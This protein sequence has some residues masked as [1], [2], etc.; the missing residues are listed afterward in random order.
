MNKKIIIS[1]IAILIVAIGGG[2]YYTTSKNNVASDGHTDHS[3]DEA[4][5]MGTDMEE[6]HNMD[7]M[8]SGAELAGTRI[9]VKN[10][11]FKSGEQVLSFVVYGKD[12]HE[13]GDKDL[14]VTHEKKMHFIMASADFSSYQHIH[15]EF[16]D[17]SWQATILLNNNTAY[18]AYVDIDST[19][20]GA[21]VL[22][23]PIAVGAP[24]A[25]SKVSQK[26]TSV[27]KDGVEV[28]LNAENGFVTGKDNL[29]TFTLS[30]GGKNIVPENYL[31]AKGHVIA[32][33]EDP[34]SFIHGHPNE[35]GDNDTHFAFNFAKAGTYTLF[36]QFQV[37]GAVNTYPFTITVASSN[38][39]VDESKPHVDAVP[40]N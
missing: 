26:E 14:K 31:G 4:T 30:K 1:I 38:G 10:S 33:S 40:H 19:E 20:V 23:L 21:E 16:K 34:N 11:T 13:W 37:A 35:H 39:V 29:I 22:R 3:H 32:L 27:T 18:Q 8:K 24:K 5:S 6:T 7:A 15:P 9:I 17:G 12:G 28:K 36:A 25:V 2:V